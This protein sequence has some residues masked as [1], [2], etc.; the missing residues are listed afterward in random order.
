MNPTLRITHIATGAD[1]L[2]VQ[3]WQADV[4]PPEPVSL[5]AEHRLAPGDTL[6]ICLR[7]NQ[8]IVI[9]PTRPSF[10]RALTDYRNTRPPNSTTAPSAADIA[11]ALMDDRIDA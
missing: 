8:H 4:H 1:A 5:V 6:P 2:D 10:A 9:P 3:I 11:R 7:E